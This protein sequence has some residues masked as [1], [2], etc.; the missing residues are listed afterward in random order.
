MEGDF[1][2]GADAP[3]VRF[4]DRRVDLHVREVVGDHEQRGR[5]QRGR[6]R[7]AHVHVAGHHHA[8]D[9]R[10]DDGVGQVDLGLLDGGRGL[11]HVRRRGLQRRHRALVVG[12]GGVEVGRGDELLRGQ[13]LGAVV[14][15]LGVCH[16]GLRL[17]DVGLG[18]HQVRTRLAQAGIER[19]GIQPRHHLVLPHPRVEVGVEARD[20]AR[21]LRSDLHRGDRLEGAGGAH[22]VHDVTAVDGGGRVL[23]LFVPAAEGQH[24]GGGQDHDAQGDQR[25][26]LGDTHTQ[27]L[28]RMDPR[29]VGSQEVKACHL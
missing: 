14:L 9:G 18:R 28:D 10:A 20:G 21:D 6:H 11:G 22:D 27:S 17:L 4:V 12:L 23:D 3:D 26:S 29:P 24:G 16:R 19:R 25:G 15:L 1:L 8:V 2:S 7:L 5:L 13:L